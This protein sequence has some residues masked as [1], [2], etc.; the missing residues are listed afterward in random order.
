MCCVA[1]QKLFV[2]VNVQRS[3]M[4]R[5]CKGGKKEYVSLEISVNPMYWDFEKNKPKRNCSNNEMV[6]VCVYL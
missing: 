6:S 2:M 3:I 1:N 4:L 5:V